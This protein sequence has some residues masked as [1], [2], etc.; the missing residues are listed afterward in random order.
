MT[1]ILLI[2]VSLLM[3][4][5]LSTAAVAADIAATDTIIVTATRNPVSVDDA[6]VPVHVITRAD[7]ELSLASDLADLLRFEAGFDIARQ[8]GPGQATSLFLRGTESNHTLVLIDGVRINPGTLGGAALQNISP[9]T[10]QRVEIVKGARS[11]LYG[12]DAVGGVIN[13]IT[14][15]ADSNYLEMGINAGSFNTRG[16]NVSAGSNSAAGE[17]GITLDWR[18]TDGY[19]PRTDSDIIRGYDN[20]SVNVYGARRFANNE[21]TLRHWRAG[22]TVEYLDFFLTPVDQ[23]FLNSATALELNTSVGANGNSKAILSYMQD[24]IEQNQ[25]PDFVESNRTSL[26][27]QYAHVLGKQTVTAGLYYMDENAKSLSFGSGFDENTR[28]NAVYLQDQVDLD[29]QRAFFAVRFTDHESFGNQVTWNAEYAF[30]INDAWTLGAGFGSAFRAPDATDRYGFGGNPELDPETADSLNV[31]LRFLPAGPHRVELE[32]YRD[33]IKDLIEFDFAS[34][35]LMNIDEADIHGTELSYEYRGESFS[36]RTELVSQVADNVT[37]GARL[38]R[39]AE[40]SATLNYTQNFGQHRLGVSVIASGDREDIG[41]VELGSFIVV[42]LTGQVKLSKH[43]QLNARI[44][45]LFDENYQT[46]DGYRMQ[47]LSGYLE[48]NYRLR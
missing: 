11:A 1:R 43:W 8:G 41:G 12:T 30:D 35:S 33:D 5:L 20:L 10:I 13:V 18:D 45:N 47:E 39:R 9:D 44:E 15:R 36:L 40:K 31:S 17:L 22:G 16:A 27:W 48:L 6:I 23:D 29:R 19:A 38:L 24:D 42:D 28:V 3:V 34:F 37:S 2:S 4:S 14:R 26:D 7:I 46:A 32:Y 21:L 25:S